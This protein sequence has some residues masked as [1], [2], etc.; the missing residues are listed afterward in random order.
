MNINSYNITDVSYHYIGLQ[1]LAG[2]PADA[3]RSSQVSEISRNVLKFVT[4][5]ALRLMLPQPSGTFESV[6]EKICR[7]LVHFQFAHSIKGRYEVTEDGHSV[8]NL[9]ASR[10]YIALRRLMAQVHLQTYDNLRRIVQC[11]I[12]AG[13]VWMPVVEAGSMSEKGYLEELLKPTFGEE[14]EIEVAKV[15]SEQKGLNR[16]K[17]QDALY[18]RILQQMMPDQ[19]IGVANFKA[20]RDRL[21]SLRL[22][23]QR[24]MNRGECEFTVSYSPCATDTPERTWYVPLDVPLQDGKSFRIFFCEPDMTD[25]CHQDV[26]LAAIDEAFRNL[27]QEGG[28]YDI[29]DLRDWVCQHLLIPE[30][31]FDDGLNQLLDWQPQVLSVGLQ[32]DRIS[33]RRRPLVRQHRDAALHNL[34]RRV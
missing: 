31:A 11:H 17:L 4:N 23:N 34:V 26:L 32:Y 33:A 9:L 30:A 24:Q 10:D 21:G 2:I 8:L 16:G 15:K 20:I 6:G 7:E 18:D 27:K 3:D 5:R 1:V 28:Y 25:R 29:P 13:N 12:E 19:R 14:S 22:L